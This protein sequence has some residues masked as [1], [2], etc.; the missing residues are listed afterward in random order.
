MLLSI[1]V[2]TESVSVCQHVWYIDA[3][4]GGALGL[5][6]S[7]YENCVGA[8]HPSKA[9]SVLQ[10]SLSKFETLGFCALMHVQNADAVCHVRF[11]A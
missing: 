1:H 9:A 8:K 11:N 2:G 6:H 10:F 3:H 5:V 7:W 4:S